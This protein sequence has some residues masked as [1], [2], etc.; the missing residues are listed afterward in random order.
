MGGA[1]VLSYAIQTRGEGLKGVIASSPLIRQAKVA[2]ANS[3]LVRVGSGIGALLPG[4]TL[5]APVN[6]TVRIPF[7][8][9]P[10]FQI[11]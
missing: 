1:R 3:L 10:P 6:P 2:K 8:P 4:M 11:Q 5:K 7:P 9:I